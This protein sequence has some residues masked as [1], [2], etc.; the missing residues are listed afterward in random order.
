MMNLI[1]QDLTFDPEQSQEA[2][3]NLPPRRCRIHRDDRALA[4]SSDSNR[5]SIPKLLSRTGGLHVGVGV[6][7][8]ASWSFGRVG[9]VL[10]VVRRTF[11]LFSD[12]IIG[13]KSQSRG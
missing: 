10:L 5:A 4:V 6:V 2:T 12:L 3:R 13:C 1:D 11:N 7:A 9:F 8:R